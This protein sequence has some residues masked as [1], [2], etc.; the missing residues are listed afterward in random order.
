MRLYI[1]LTLSLLLLSLHSL[2]QGIPKHLEI[3]ISYIGTTEA[4]GH[5]DGP[6]IEKIIKH[7]GGAK[8]AS[9]CGYFVKI[10]LDSANAKLP[11][12]RGGMAIMYKTKNSIPANDVLIGKTKVP[13]GS[14]VVFGKGNTIYGHTGFT[15]RTW[16]GQ[17][18]RT[19]E[20]NTSSGI[21][22]SQSNGDGIYVRKRKIE[23]LNYFR[24]IC[25]T[26]VTY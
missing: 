25:F 12:R 2:N 7:G 8:G 15:I 18:G 4:T 20:A 23:P 6:E 11:T 14:I 9:Y 26:K 21:S 13:V 10:C 3:A 24:I 1:L 22:G 5:N 16:N 17:S 19:V